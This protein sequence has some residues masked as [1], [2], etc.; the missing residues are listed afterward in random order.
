MQPAVVEPADVLATVCGA[1][2]LTSS[3]LAVTHPAGEYAR[4]ADCPLS[5]AANSDCLRAKG[6]T[7]VFSLLVDR[8]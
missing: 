7:G 3:A 4:Y 6:A 5:N 8:S 1:L 2:A